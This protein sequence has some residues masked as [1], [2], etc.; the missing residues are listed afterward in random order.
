MLSALV[1]A[2]RSMLESR[3]LGLVERRRPS[4][5][6]KLCKRW[7]RKL[8]RREEKQGRFEKRMA[9]LTQ[10]I[11]EKFDKDF[12]GPTKAQ[13]KTM[14][15]AQFKALFVDKATKAEMETIKESLNKARRHR[16][17]V[18]RLQRYRNRNTRLTNKINKIKGVCS[19]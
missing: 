16:H 15:M 5:K 10:T 8:K 17:T 9:Q 19:K 1:S 11:N 4:A 3:L 12:I 6:S 7:Q 14:V 2:E 13:I 18:K